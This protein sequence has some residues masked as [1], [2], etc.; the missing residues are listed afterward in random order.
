MLLGPNHRRPNRGGEEFS[1]LQHLPPTNLGPNQKKNKNQSGNTNLRKIC[2]QTK[3]KWADRHDEQF[4]IKL[5]DIR[6]VIK[7]SFALKIYIILF[8][9]K[10]NQNQTNQSGNTSLRRIWGQ[11][12]QKLADLHDEQFELKL[13]D[14]RFVIKSSFTLNIYII[15]FHQKFW[16]NI[17]PFK[18]TVWQH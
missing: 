16:D 4:V 9:Q 11:T 17:K 15:L 8:H 10:L 5:I 1:S 12:K 3:Q 14:F 18:K 2:G 7:R 6:F 13:I